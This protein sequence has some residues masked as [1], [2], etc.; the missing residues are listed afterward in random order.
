MHAISHA[1]GNTYHYDAYG[2]MSQRAGKRLDYNAF[3]KITSIGGTTR[4]SYGP[5][6][7]RFKQV[8]GNKTTY[9]LAGGSYEEIV[10][11]GL[12]TQKSYVG[13]YFVQ[14][15]TPGDISRSYLHRDHIGSVEAM[16]DKAGFLLERNSFSAWGA[17]QQGDWS[18]GMPSL[19]DLAQLPTT[20]G[21][22]GHEMLDDSGLVH[23]NGRVYDP[24]LGRFLNADIFIQ[25]PYNSQS[26][27]RYSYVFNNP[28]SLVDPSGYSAA[29]DRN[30]AL[31]NLDKEIERIRVRGYQYDYRHQ[32]LSYG[33]MS[34]LA[35]MSAMNQQMMMGTNGGGSGPCSADCTWAQVIQDNWKDILRDTVQSTRETSSLNDALVDFAGAEEIVEGSINIAEGNTKAG[36]QAVIAMALGK[37]KVITKVA[38]NLPGTRSEIHVDLTEK[39]YK[40]KGVS[41]NNGYTTYKGPDGKIVTIKPTGEVIPTQRVWKS[42]GSGKFPQRQD[43][44]SGNALQNQSHSTGHFVEPAV[45][46]YKGNN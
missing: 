12:T 22:T 28:L 46:P 4:F 32:F 31:N 24:S 17:R 19:A 40:F 13:D 38:G 33:H 41:Q 26:F 23:M 35:N 44:N 8:K 3:N 1:D 2:N 27:N 45:G 30:N 21:F 34:M 16:T 18:T 15:T 37:V 25:A 39:G 14:S 43:Y 9:Y 10:D 11:S 36:A 7:A 5:D 20:R 6:H 42:D 29:D